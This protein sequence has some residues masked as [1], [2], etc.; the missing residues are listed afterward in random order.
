M[1]TDAP[2]VAADAPLPEVVDAVCSTRLNRAVVVD[3]ENRVIGVISDAAVLGALGPGGGGVVGAL[4]RG[5][6]L[7]DGP[8]VTARDLMGTTT[9]SVTA[10]EAL[11]AV[12]RVMTEHR[13]KI[14]PVVDA[15][16]HLLGVIDRADLLQATH[17]ALRELT[18]T[19]VVDEE[20]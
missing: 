5:V 13:R 14:V 17:D 16:G 11:S 19:A 9:H 10:D 2:V 6:G 12:A 4:M 8:R 7:A 3:D 18:A 15:E 1:R 20:D